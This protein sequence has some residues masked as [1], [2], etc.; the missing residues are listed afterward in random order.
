MSFACWLLV[1]CCFMDS[2]PLLVLFSLI[3]S[4]GLWLLCGCLPLHRLLQNNGLWSPAYGMTSKNSS[5][6]TACWTWISH[7]QCKYTSQTTF[8]TSNFLRPPSNL[9]FFLCSSGHQIQTQIQISRHRIFS[10]SLIINIRF[11]TVFSL[12]SVLPCPS[13]S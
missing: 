13:S 10:V 5:S 2:H 9:L 12:Q 11:A 7:W 8:I 6:L 4:H 3:Q 1:L